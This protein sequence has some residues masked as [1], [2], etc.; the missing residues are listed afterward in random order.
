MHKKCRRSCGLCGG[1]RPTNLPT[2]STRFITK[3]GTIPVTVKPATTS[4]TGNLVNLSELPCFSSFYIQ[5][6]NELLSFFELIGG[7]T[8]RDE[9]SDC[10]SI[11]RKKCAEKYGFWKLYMS[12]KC[13][14]FCKF[15]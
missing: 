9:G 3:P 5:P 6:D 11:G 13:K 2:R 10:A 8:C 4:S 1:P 15:C 14:K 12:G 7:S